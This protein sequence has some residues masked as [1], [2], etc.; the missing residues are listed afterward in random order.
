MV[1]QLADIEGRQIKALLDIT[2]DF[3]LNGGDRDF[4]I[5]V[6][7]SDYDE[8]MSSGGRVFIAD[9]EIGGIIGE[10]RTDTSTDTLYWSGYTW[11]GLLFMK[12]ITPPEGQDYYTVSGELN[13]ILRMLIE[14]QF[15]GV[16]VVP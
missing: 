9:T 4:E 15:S 16:F 8:R 7:I 6:S 11:R 14:P 3:E 10:L 13:D 2:A 5:E 1:M 12:V